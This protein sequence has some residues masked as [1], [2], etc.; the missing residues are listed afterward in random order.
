MIPITAWDMAD[1]KSKDITRVALFDSQTGEWTDITDSVLAWECIGY[2]RADA[3]ARMNIPPIAA[4]PA[5]PCPLCARPLPACQCGTTP[6]L[7][8]RFVK[9]GFY[10]VCCTCGLTVDYCKGH[11]PPDAQSADG[12]ESHLVARIREAMG[13]R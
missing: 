4:L 13:G 3:T 8:S 9:K 1:P 2:G 6:A 5:P 10:M 12:S 7:P 11:G